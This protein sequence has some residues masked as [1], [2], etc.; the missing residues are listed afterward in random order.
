GIAVVSEIEEALQFRDIQAAVVSTQAR[1]HFDVAR[2]CLEA[3]KHVLVE[4]PMVTTTDCARSLVELAEK[5]GLVLMVGHIF[6]YNPGITMIKSYIDT[7]QAGDIYYLYTRRTNLGPVRHDVN[8][9][10][11]LASHDVAIL[12]FL[13]NQRP[14][15]VSAVG[16]RVL[17]NCREDVGFVVLHYPNNVLGHI[18]VSWAEPNKVRELVVVGSEKRIVFNDLDS[19][20]RVRIFDKGITALYADSEPSSYGEYHFSIRDGDIVSPHIEVSEPLKNQ[21]NHFID[22]VIDHKRPISDGQSGLVVVHIMEAACQ[23]L[24]VNGVPVYL[25]WNRTDHPTERMSEA[26]H[27]YSIHS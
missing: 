14:E 7:K 23:S 1:T 9:L 17:H 15:W 18:H 5:N 20:E 10:W 27:A 8:A 22:C 4:K 11:D 12:N 3:G 24:E 13:L 19:Q 2:R 16:S 6:L 26:N 21:C 25:D